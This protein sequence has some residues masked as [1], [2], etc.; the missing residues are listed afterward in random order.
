[1][2]KVLKY[3]FGVINFAGKL[4]HRED[5]RKLSAHIEDLFGEDVA[6]AVTSKADMDKSHF[7]FPNRDTDLP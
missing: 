2:L 5:L 1:M 7:G 3:I 4:N 6:L